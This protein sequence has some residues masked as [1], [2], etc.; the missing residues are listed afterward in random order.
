MLGTHIVC[1]V[2]A[3]SD[4]ACLQSWPPMMML[5]MESEDSAVSGLQL[6]PLF[7]TFHELQE[8]CQTECTTFRF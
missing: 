5:S 7:N 1:I 2:K 6:S 3:Y 4:E 8:L